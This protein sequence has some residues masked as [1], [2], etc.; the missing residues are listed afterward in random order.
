MNGWV[1]LLILTTMAWCFKIFKIVVIC[2]LLVSFGLG[3]VKVYQHFVDIKD[4][5]SSVGDVKSIKDLAW[6]PFLIMQVSATIFMFLQIYCLIRE[7]CED[8]YMYKHCFRCAFV[9]TVLIYSISVFPKS[10]LTIIYHNYDISIE[11]WWTKVV[12]VLESLF[13]NLGALGFQIILYMRIFKRAF[14]SAGVC[15]KNIVVPLYSRNKHR[16]I[17]S[18]DD[19]DK[20]GCCMFGKS[21]KVKDDAKTGDTDT[22]LDAVGNKRQV[23]H[24]IGNAAAVRRVTEK[25]RKLENNVTKVS[26]W[27]ETKEKEA[28]DLANRKKAAVVTKVKTN[29]GVKYISDKKVKAESKIENAK[30]AAKEKVESGQKKANPSIYLAKNKKLNSKEGIGDIYCSN[31]GLYSSSQ[32][33]IVMKNN[34]NIIAHTKNFPESICQE[35]GKTLSLQDSDNGSGENT[36]KVTRCCRK[37][38][39]KL[40]CICENRPLCF[41]I[42][43]TLANLHMLVYVI[44]IF[45]IFCPWC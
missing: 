28:R 2:M 23:V 19:V 24:G 45:F 16:N 33:D 3:Y 14:R 38:G 26:A 34:N 13:N 41:I 10:I 18:D 20:T 40:C 15:R 32:T 12:D 22:E 1:P 25:K 37:L 36:S 42:T 39:A 31:C 6:I 8:N 44:E 43:M 11:E 4:T 35:C 7:L 17:D 30:A 21:N 27:K 9:L 5:L 29:A